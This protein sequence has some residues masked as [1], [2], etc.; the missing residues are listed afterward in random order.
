MEFLRNIAPGS[1]ELAGSVILLCFVFLFIILERFYPYK[2]NV[3]LFRKGFWMDLV[4]YTFI[5]S[6]FLK[7]LIFDIII[8]PF[9]NWI[10][11]GET[12]ILSHWPILI[13]ILFF[14]I[15]HDLYIYWFHRWQ[16]HSKVLWRTHEAHHS[17]KDVDWLAG[18][19]SHALEILI[20]QTIEFLPIFLLLDVKTA[21]IIVPIKALLD[22]VW[23]MW[24]HSNIDVKSGKLQ[25]IFNGPEMHQWHHA[26]HKEVFYANYSTKFAFW[27]WMFGTAFLPGLNPPKWA[28]T[29]PVAYGL[30]YPYP[31]DFFSQTVYA[32]FRFDLSKLFANQTYRFFRDIRKKILELPILGKYKRKLYDIFIDDSNPD[33]MIDLQLRACEQCSKPMK[34]FYSSNQLNWQCEHCENHSYAELNKFGV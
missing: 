4:W 14:L 34:Y 6:Y 11:L 5:Q 28:I 20:N 19:R 2:K 7:I 3:K 23:G 29:K 1:I 33:Y 30:P 22:A 15:T 10:G 16:H 27:D 18:S 32:L 17:V 21:A 31:E 26:N 13:L 24:I 25:Y 8:A 12:G 9:K